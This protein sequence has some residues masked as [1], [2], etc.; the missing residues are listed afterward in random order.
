MWQRQ[1][2]LYEMFTSR[3]L[4]NYILSYIILSSQSSKKLIS[5]P[6]ETA[7]LHAACQMQIVFVQKEFRKCLSAKNLRGKILAT[8][9][10][11]I[12]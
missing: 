11:I 4:R 1:P 3:W 7:S 9:D 8:S 12:S 2:N 6:A 10:D 5:D